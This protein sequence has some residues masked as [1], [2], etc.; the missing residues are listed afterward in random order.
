MVAPVADKAGAK[1]HHPAEVEMDVDRV[2]RP[3][4][5]RAKP[6]IPVQLGRRRLLLAPA[7]GEVG[8]V[9][10]L[11]MRY[12]PD[13]AVADIFGGDFGVGV[14]AALRADLDHAPVFVGGVYHRLAFLDGLAG[15][16]LAVDILA[17][18]AGVDGHD[19]VPVVGRADGDGVYILTVEDVAVIFGKQRRALNGLGDLG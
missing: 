3:P 19:G 6:Q 1:T 13:L 12:L 17:G 11:H 2:I 15:R 14:G 7:I 4:A 16:L 10:D 5:C 18:L 9:P 8:R